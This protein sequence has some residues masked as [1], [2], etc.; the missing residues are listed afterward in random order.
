MCRSELRHRLHS[1]SKMRFLATVFDFLAR[2]PLK[3]LMG[4]LHKLVVLDFG[5]KNSDIS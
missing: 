2:F 5:V 1:N 4:F 3:F